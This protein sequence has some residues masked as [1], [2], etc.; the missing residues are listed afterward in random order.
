MA[1]TINFKLFSQARYGRPGFHGTTVPVIIPADIH[2]VTRPTEY[3][4][5]LAS[6]LSD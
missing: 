5:S 3:P 2:L 1:A 4:V 6:Q